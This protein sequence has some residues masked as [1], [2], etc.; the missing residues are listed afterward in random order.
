MFSH[1]TFFLLTKITFLNKTAEN[2]E[3]ENSNLDLFE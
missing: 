3:I 2:L 1:N